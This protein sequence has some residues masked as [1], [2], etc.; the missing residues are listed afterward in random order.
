MTLT[1]RTFDGAVSS[2]RFILGDETTMAANV[3]GPALG[4][5]KAGL[6]F[7]ERGFFGVFGSAEIMPRFVQ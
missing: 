3:V 1:G 2:H 5:M 4:W 6:E 7:H